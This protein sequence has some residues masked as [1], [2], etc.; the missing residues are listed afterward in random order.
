MKHEE[1]CRRWWGETRGRKSEKM[2]WNTRKNVR[3]NKWDETRRKTFPF[4]RCSTQPK[5]TK[6]E[7]ASRPTRRLMRNCF[8]DNP[9]H[10]ILNNSKLAHRIYVILIA[11]K[12][13]I[14]KIV[15]C[16]GPLCIWN[17]GSYLGNHTNLFGFQSRGRNMAAPWQR[18]S[19]NMFSFLI[20]DKQTSWL[21]SRF[22]SSMKID[23]L[24]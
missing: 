23:S 12:E 5:K 13:L 8:L 21:F 2:G 24:H 1:E 22:A 17:D 6:K 19:F 9:L 3:E 11:N 10:V 7:L 16:W 4:A 15:R 20:K 18:V 14:K